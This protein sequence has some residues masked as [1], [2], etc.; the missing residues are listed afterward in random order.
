M[1]IMTHVSHLSHDQLI[2]EYAI[3][4]ANANKLVTIIVSLA[5]AIG[6]T[7]IAVISATH[8]EEKRGIEAKLA[9]KAL[10]RR[11]DRHATQDFPETTGLNGPHFK[12][13]SLVIYPTAIRVA[14][15]TGPF[16]ANIFTQDPPGSSLLQL[17]AAVA[18]YIGLFSVLVAMFPGMSF[19]KNA[20]IG[21][22]I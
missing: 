12:L 7:S 22:V 21:M 15:L 16:V 11:I 20:I 19:F 13:F 10:P 1:P 9:N 3:F 17:T 14:V 4:G 2:N 8:S 5:V 18:G 6:S